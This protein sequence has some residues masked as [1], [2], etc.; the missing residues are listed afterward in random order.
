MR[1]A[2]ESGSR[3]ARSLRLARQWCSER[4][5]RPGAQVH[6]HR[7]QGP[8]PIQHA[9]ACWSGPVRLSVYSVMVVM[10]DVV[11]D[12]VAEVDARTIQ[13]APG[14]M[15]SLSCFHGSCGSAQY[16][17]TRH[18]SQLAS[19]KIDPAAVPSVLAR[20]SGSPQA[21]PDE[22]IAAQPSDQLFQQ[23]DRLVRGIQRFRWT[24]TLRAPI[25]L[26][27][28]R[29]HGSAVTCS[30]SGISAASAATLRPTKLTVSRDR[31]FDDLTSHS[32]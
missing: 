2:R 19:S 14:A 8:L 16:R 9:S 22:A 23:F 12:L 17:C 26:Q 18:A 4:G 29:H 25:S 32:T 24:A 3:A 31:G 28:C 27:C 20:W 13:D 11:G 10:S 15:N 5:S 6:R 30:T 7:A 21:H 1:E